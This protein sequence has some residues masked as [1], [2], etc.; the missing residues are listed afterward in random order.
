MIEPTYLKE[1]IIQNPFYDGTHNQANSNIY[2]LLRRRRK[3]E[4]YNGRFLQVIKSTKQLSWLS[5]FENKLYERFS[6][7]KQ[8][9]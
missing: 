4:G 9:R 1:I 6:D 2:F 7:N 3:K 8:K 5:I